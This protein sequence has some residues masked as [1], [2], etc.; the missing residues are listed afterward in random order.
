VMILVPHML[1]VESGNF[2]CHCVTLQPMETSK[3]MLG[4]NISCGILT[5]VIGHGVSRLR[6][7]ASHCIGILER[8]L[9]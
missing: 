9:Y 4:C 7:E 6:K 5:D 1:T 2:T 8:S 3:D